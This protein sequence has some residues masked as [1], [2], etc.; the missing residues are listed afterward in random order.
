MGLISRVSSRTYRKKMGKKP[1]KP[2]SLS[3]TR[4]TG[5]N[6][7]NS[8]TKKTK[9]GNKHVAEAWDHS[10]SMKK[11]LAPIGLASDPNKILP[12]ETMREKLKKQMK[13]E[14]ADRLKVEEKSVVEKPEVLEKLEADAKV[15]LKSKFRITR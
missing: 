1:F 3:K 8:G 10:K 12:V 11:N 9:I 5:K 7:R 13:K 4:R 6:Q 15:K 14:D 2:K